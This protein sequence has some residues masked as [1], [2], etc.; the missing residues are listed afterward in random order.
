[1][2]T[3]FS[4]A[5]WP[6]ENRICFEASCFIC[7]NRRNNFA[8]TGGVNPHTSHEQSSTFAREF[9]RGLA[10]LGRSRRSMADDPNDSRYRGRGFILQYG[11][12]FPRQQLRRPGEFASMNNQRSTDLPQHS[13]TLS[14][15]AA[16]FVPRSAPAYVENGDNCDADQM[17]CLETT[18][19]AMMEITVNPGRFTTLSQLL[20]DALNVN[21]PNE[22]TLRGVA[23]LV[24]EQGVVEPN[25]RYTGAKL[26][27]HL[28]NNLNVQFGGRN[29]RSYLMERCQEEFQQC[30]D[31]LSDEVLINRLRGY[32]MFMAELYSHFEV[33]DGVKSQKV[34]IIENALLKLLDILLLECTKDN[35]KTVC[36]VLKLTGAALKDNHETRDLSTDASSLNNI[37]LQVQQ[38]ST[39][40]DIDRNSRAML[41]NV[42]ELNS[43]DWGRMTRNQPAPAPQGHWPAGPVPRDDPSTYQA[44][45]DRP[46]MYGPDGQPL[47]EEEIHFIES[48]QTR[49]SSIHDDD[50]PDND[51]LRN[52][53]GHYGPRSTWSGGEAGDGGGMDDEM[54]AAFEQF[55]LE[56]GQ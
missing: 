33:T 11:K 26:C 41:Q 9:A 55:L 20:V 16:E 37:I 40:P 22:E 45:I 6:Q 34:A 4:N 28:A 25:F 2:K 56:S 54:T 36:Q 29:F 42:L 18:R 35:L 5:M 30:E 12:P 13:H 44:S 17:A 24:F 10:S 50:E 3:V 19:L 14:P 7:F 15:H 8:L 47:T 48:N 31:M 46:V 52:L 1:M 43:C 23:Q 49:G 39:K 21:M 27:N 32:T 51:E 38:V 53:V